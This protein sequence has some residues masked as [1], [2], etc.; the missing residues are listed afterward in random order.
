M[1]RLPLLGNSEAAGVEVVPR[2]TCGDCMHWEAADP[3]PAAKRG[4]V[5]LTPQRDKK[6]RQGVCWKGPYITVPVVT[7]ASQLPD[8]SVVPNIQSFVTIGK[9]TSDLPAPNCFEPRD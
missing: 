2:K 9:P 8:G 3:E 1:N 7:G 4:A 5:L 6:P